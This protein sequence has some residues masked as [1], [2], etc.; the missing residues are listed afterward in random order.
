MIT[1]IDI[2]TLLTHYPLIEKLVGSKTEQEKLLK[3]ISLI[4]KKF[5]QKHIQTLSMISKVF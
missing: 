2:H 1:Q 4:L 5:Y 3:N